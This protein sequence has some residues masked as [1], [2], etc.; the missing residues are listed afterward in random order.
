MDRRQAHLTAID[1]ALRAAKLTSVEKVRLLDLRLRLSVFAADFEPDLLP[2]ERE[3]L[4]W[5]VKQARRS[6]NLGTTLLVMALTGM[7]GVGIEA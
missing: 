4:D 3:F 2:E 5:L 1:D 7:C 6:A